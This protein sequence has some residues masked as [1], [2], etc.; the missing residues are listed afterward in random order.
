MPSKAQRTQNQIEAVGQ[1]LR[2]GNVRGFNATAMLQSKL[3]SAIPSTGVMRW[4][5][6]SHPSGWGNGLCSEATQSRV[7]PSN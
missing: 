7:F 2:L 3:G 1:I 5:K 6:V 4:H